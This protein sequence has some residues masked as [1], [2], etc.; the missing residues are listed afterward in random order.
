VVR[1]KDDFCGFIG[2]LGDRL[3]AAMH[4]R[5]SRLE[6]RLNALLARPG[7]ASHRGRIA[8]RGRH[9]AELTAALRHAMTGAAGRRARRHELLARA[10][11]QFDPRH[12]LNA[13]KTR[14]VAREGQ[15]AHAA[16]RRIHLSDARFKSLAAR[17]EG[18]S[19][20]AVLARGY[21]VAWDSSHSRIIRDAST[22]TPGEEIVVR[23]ERGEIRSTVT[24]TNS[25]PQTP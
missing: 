6:S 23:V 3:D 10:L 16:A 24:H 21:A 17:L 2:R 14:L 11:T 22:V 9:V 25:S 5:V 8:M 4:R 1:R 12:R 18:L 15:L 13:V 7:Y 20:L 19:P